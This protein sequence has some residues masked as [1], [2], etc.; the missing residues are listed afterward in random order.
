MSQKCKTRAHRF[1]QQN[2][3]AFQ[4]FVWCEQAVAFLHFEGS[5]QWKR[6]ALSTS[7]LQNRFTVGF[8]WWLWRSVAA[9]LPLGHLSRGLWRSARAS[10]LLQQS[11]PHLIIFCRIFASRVSRWAGKIHLQFVV[12]YV[13][14][15][16]SFGRYESK[17]NI[18]WTSGP[19]N[20][21]LVLSLLTSHFFIF[22]RRPSGLGSPSFK[23]LLPVFSPFPEGDRP[24]PTR[25]HAAPRI[26][27][28]N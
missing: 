13:C 16:V 6:L 24:S 1:Q 28:R 2:V 18:L 15:C 12:V 19:I 4:N 17:W 10:R 27:R 23:S 9:S 26:K 3:V 22:P 11:A 5:A 8:Q 7:S 20:C 21:P 14:V 25:F